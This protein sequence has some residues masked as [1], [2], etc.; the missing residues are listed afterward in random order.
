MFYF[1]CLFFS[2]SVCIKELR[3]VKFG[4][5]CCSNGFPDQRQRCPGRRQTLQAE[6]TKMYCNFFGVHCYIS[7][8]LRYSNSANRIRILVSYWSVRIFDYR[9]TVIDVCALSEFF[10]ATRQNAPIP[11]GCMD[12][13]CVL[14]NTTLVRRSADCSREILP[15][16][17]QRS[18]V[19]F[20]LLLYTQPQPTL[21]LKTA[22]LLLA[23]SVTSFNPFKPSDAKWLHFKAFRAILV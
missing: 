5:T 21:G 19:R 9:H 6:L 8:D 18:S 7:N 17:Q 4:R 2:E 3:F 11:I 1:Q 20:S 22:G 15:I 16:S 12:T 14:M 23:H 13:N 10:S